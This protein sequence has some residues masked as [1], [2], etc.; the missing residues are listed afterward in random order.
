MLFSKERMGAIRGIH[1]SI[2]V[3]IILEAIDI[4]KKYG[5][6]AILNGIDLKDKAATWDHNEQ[7]GGHKALIRV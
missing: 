6:N 7:V 4:R 1:L 3:S 5:G 2:L